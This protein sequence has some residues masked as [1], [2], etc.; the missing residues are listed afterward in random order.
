VRP[1][2]HPMKFFQLQLANPLSNISTQKVFEG[3]TFRRKPYKYEAFPLCGLN[4]NQSVH[5]SVEVA[6]PGKLRSDNESAGQIVS[7]AMV[8]KAEGLSF[9]FSILPHRRSMVTSNIKESAQTPVI[10]PNA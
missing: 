7:P 8:R 2:F 10:T 1:L 9:S 6:N 3:W 5:R 4:R